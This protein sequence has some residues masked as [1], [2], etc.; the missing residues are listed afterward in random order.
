MLVTNNLLEIPEL[1][2]EVAKASF[3]KGNAIMKIRNEL[4]T[5]KKCV[6]GRKLG[7]IDVSKV[8]DNVDMSN[9]IFLSQPTIPGYQIRVRIIDVYPIIWRR[10]LFRSDNTFADLHYA[11]QIAMNWSD[12]FLH[13]FK[14]QGKVIGIPRAHGIWVSHSANVSTLADFG[15]Q[16]NQRF[17]YEYNFFDNWQIEV[18]I[19]KL[20]QVPVDKFYPRCIGGKRS[21]PPESCGGVAGFRRLRQ[22]YSTAYLRERTLEFYELLMEEE[23]LTEELYYEIQ[24]RRFELARLQYWLNIDTFKRLPVNNRLKLYATKDENWRYHEE[25]LA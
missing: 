6:L 24:D 22:H 2:V 14:L 4:E 23:V 21:A 5:I 15:L 10:F 20:C 11:I 13:Q 17:L 8:P 9:Q 3:P 16:P 25:V 7:L 1:T 19:E 18:R 12:D